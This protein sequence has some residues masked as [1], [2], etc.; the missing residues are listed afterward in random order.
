MWRPICLSLF[1]NTPDVA[2][3]GSIRVTSAEI[4]RLKPAEYAVVELLRCGLSNKAIAR[5]LKTSEAMVKSR[6]HK[7][8]AS[9][10]LT[11]ASS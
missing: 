1:R 11:T 4:Q 2:G 5:E 3:L 10:V 9:S 7:L 8:I 6:L